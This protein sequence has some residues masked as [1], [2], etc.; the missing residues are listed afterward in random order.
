MQQF[1][2]DMLIVYQVRPVKAD[3]IHCILRLHLHRVGLE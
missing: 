1:V 3:K 2:S